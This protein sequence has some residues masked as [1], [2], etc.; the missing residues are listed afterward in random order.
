MFK[1]LIFT[2]FVLQFCSAAKILGIFQ[3]PVFSHHQFNVKIMKELAFRGHEVTM[4]STFKL[5]NQTKNIKFHHFQESYE[6]YSKIAPNSV[7]FKNKKVNFF[8]FYFY[9]GTK[10]FYK[11]TENQLQ[12]PE[13]QKI[14]NEKFDLIIMEC[15]FCPFKF[16]ADI[17][18]CPIVITTSSDAPT[19]WHYIFGNDVNPLL[20]SEI[21]LPYQHENLTFTQKINSWIFYGLNKI[22]ILFDL[23]SKIEENLWKKFMQSQKFQKS[24]KNFNFKF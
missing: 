22:N 23:R 20:Y 13:M 16:L 1:K 18:D 2:I 10:V 4:F 6:I 19:F 17:F 5:K 15:F 9:Y 3:Y 7:D 12:H 14:F 24:G 8:T 21:V 11:T